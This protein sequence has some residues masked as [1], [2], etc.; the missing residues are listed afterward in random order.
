MCADNSQR[1]VKLRNAWK[2]SIQLAVFLDR[3]KQAIRERVK[4]DVIYNC[5]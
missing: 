5:L 2:Q 3:F 1:I 4:V